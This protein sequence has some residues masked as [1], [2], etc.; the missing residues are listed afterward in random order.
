MGP[1]PSLVGTATGKALGPRGAAGLCS[2]SRAKR[3]PGVSPSAQTLGN[4]SP[5]YGNSSGRPNSTR[6]A[7]RGAGTRVVAD[8]LRPETA[9][10]ELGRVRADARRS[11]PAW[12]TAKPRPAGHSPGRLSRVNR[13]PG[14][15]RWLWD[16]EFCGSIGCRWQE[17]PPNCRHIAPVASVGAVVPEAAVFGHAKAALAQLLPEAKSIGL[18]FV[19]L[20]TDPEN[21]AS[22]RVIRPGQRRSSGQHFTKPPQFGGKPGLR[23]ALRRVALP[24]LRWSR[25]AP[26]WHLAREALVLSSPRGPAPY[27]RSRL[28]SNVRP[29]DHQSVQY[30]SPP[31]VKDEDTLHCRKHH[32]VFAWGLRLG[33][34][35]RPGRVE[36]GTG[37][38]PRP[39]SVLCSH[40]G[41]APCL[42]T[43]RRFE[44]TPMASSTASVLRLAPQPRQATCRRNRSGS[45]QRFTSR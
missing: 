18:P 10:E 20:T 5:I 35:G 15:R 26:A 42:Q 12:R 11:S 13:L 39:T 34:S 45:L 37:Q 9:Q 23:F 30:P 6:R 41:S 14:F 29:R 8:N 19:E 40:A 27:R 2:A 17:E 24:N 31:L 44:R 16:G 28:S 4:A 33:R 43:G 7:C 22:Q 32:A 38:R 3:L 1:N 36:R 21:I 25:L